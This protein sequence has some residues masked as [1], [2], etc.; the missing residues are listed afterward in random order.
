MTSAFAKRRKNYLLKPQPDDRTL[1]P[2]VVC[3]GMKGLGKTRMLEEWPSVFRDAGISTNQFGVLVSYGNGHAPQ[4]RMPI[5]A[6]FGWRM[7]HRLFVEGEKV[8]TC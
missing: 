5:E 3:S 2:M 4:D 6:A 1:F 7:L 8:L